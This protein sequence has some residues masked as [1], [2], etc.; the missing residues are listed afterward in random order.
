[1]G[2][3]ATVSVV[4]VGARNVTS[5]DV[6]VAYDASVLE[7]LEIVPGTLLTLDGQ[8]IHA[9]QKIE[10]GRA[11][12]RFTRETAA[13]G[14]G[15]VAIVRFRALKAGNASLNVAGVTLTTPVGS[16]SVAAQAPGAVVVE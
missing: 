2:E 9:E 4:L 5:A 13:T 16:E 15:A 14:S 11:T 3:T 1:M 8:N 7:A 6:D 12:A 10:A